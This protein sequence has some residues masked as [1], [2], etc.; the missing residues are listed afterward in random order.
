M[1]L[2]LLGGVISLFPLSFCQVLGGFAGH[3]D[4]LVQPHPNAGV[5]R[6]SFRY[7]SVPLVSWVQSSALHCQDLFSLFW[8]TMNLI[9]TFIFWAKKQFNKKHQCCHGKNQFIQKELFSRVVWKANDLCIKW[10]NYVCPLWGSLGRSNLDRKEKP[11]L[12]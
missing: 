4:V 2:T 8:K 6:S 10:A 5:H 11:R 9:L 1:K 7:K 3:A 12:N